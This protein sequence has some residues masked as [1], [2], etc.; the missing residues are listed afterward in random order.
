MDFFTDYFGEIGR[1]V[2]AVDTGALCE[3]CDL[4]L[5]AQGAGGR[6]IAAGNGASASIASHFSVDLTK[7][8][9]VCAV[10]FNE[11]NL[12]TCLGNDYGYERWLE[13]ALE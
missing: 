3:A 10:N 1:R 8:A 9:G 13:K 7:N 6:V 11:A 2:S 12:I 5:A 4:M